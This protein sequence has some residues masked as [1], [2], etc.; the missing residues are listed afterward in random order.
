[1]SMDKNK[2]KERIKALRDKTSANGCTEAEAMA[3]AAKA[4]ELMKLAGLSELDLE[5]GQAETKSANRGHAIESRLWPVICRCT[6]TVVILD[7][8]ATG[9]HL[10]F[11]G[12]EPGPDVATYLWI[13]CNRAI[14]AEVRVFK[15]GSFYRRRRSLNT[16]RQAVADFKMGMVAR[17]AMRLKAL[18]GSLEDD[19]ER[20]I[21]SQALQVQFAKTETIKPRAQS[22]RFSEAATTGMDAGGKVNLA[23]GVNQSNEVKSLPGA[24]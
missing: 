18:F 12:S 2:L 3:A 8:R 17:L 19:A 16:K 5:V 23:H 15:A 10:V 11:F 1:M 4:A 22:L 21:A 24:A 14:K 9:D 20:Q 6:N 13:V 7:S